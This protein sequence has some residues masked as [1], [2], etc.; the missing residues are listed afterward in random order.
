MVFVG[1]RITIEVTSKLERLVFIVRISILVGWNEF[2]IFVDKALRCFNI[3][4]GDLLEAAESWDGSINIHILEIRL[5]YEIQIPL[6]G[7]LFLEHLSLLLI[8]LDTHPERMNQN[9]SIDNLG[10]GQRVGGLLVTQTASSGKYNM[11]LFRT[12][13]HL[14]IRFGVRILLGGFVI[15]FENFGA[16]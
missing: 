8:F 9:I 13:F 3:L 15:W 16:D 14:V 7:D 10:F 5:L 11:L 12:L 2:T 6:F 4:G 1:R